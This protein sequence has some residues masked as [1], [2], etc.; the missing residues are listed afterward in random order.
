MGIASSIK[1]ISPNEDTFHTLFDIG[2]PMYFEY[3]SGD[4]FNK[5]TPDIKFIKL[6]N[7]KERHG[8]MT[9]K[10][11]LNKDCKFGGWSDNSIHWG[12]YFTNYENIY[13]WITYTEE[14]MYWYREVTIPDDAKVRIAGDNSYNVN[15]IILGERKCIW[16]NGNLCLSI[17]KKNPSVIKYVIPQNNYNELCLSAIKL[18]PC[19]FVYID[20]DILNQETREK[21]FQIMVEYDGVFIHLI[22]NPTT[23]LQLTA[24]KNNILAINYIKKED[25]TD[26]MLSLAVNYLLKESL[27]DSYEKRISKI[28]SAFS[29]K[30]NGV[31]QSKKGILYW[32]NQIKYLFSDHKE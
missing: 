22:E 3:I 18:Q 5:M 15:K 1:K 25:M 4:L 13:Q 21:I 14:V 32:E 27:K 12:I 11:G 28:K 19:Y 7:Y 29:V 2:P 16:K 17:I 23:Q 24:I 6:T 20:K 10:D 26:E 8:S 30:I 31:Y 9:Y